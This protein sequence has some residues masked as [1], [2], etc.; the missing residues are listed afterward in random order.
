MILFQWDEKGW[1]N[2][3]DFPK[4]GDIIWL[5][6]EPHAGREIG[7]HNPKNGNIRRPCI[8]VSGYDYNVTTQSV[9][10]MPI[11]HSKHDNDSMKIQIVDPGLGIDGM[12]IMYQLHGYDYVSRHGEIIGSVRSNILREVLEVIPEIFEL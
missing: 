4:Q 5:D 8:V 1:I 9:Q 11:T 12:I 2:T 10:V 7:G 3:M 6:F